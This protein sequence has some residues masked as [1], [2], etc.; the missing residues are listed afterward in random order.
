MDNINKL[1]LAGMLKTVA[2]KN[3]RENYNKDRYRDEEEDEIDASFILLL[4]LYL[5]IWIY[6]LYLLVQNFSILPDWAKV[7]GILG[8]TMNNLAGGMFLTIIVVYIGKNSK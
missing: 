8:L 3:N 2:S 6:A 7:I 4:I 5:G 1:S